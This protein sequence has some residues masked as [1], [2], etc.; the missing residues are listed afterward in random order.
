MGSGSSF[1][2]DTNPTPPAVQTAT[3]ILANVIAAENNAIT[4]IN[5]TLASA[6]STLAA[7]VSAAAQSATNAANSASNA[8]TQAGNS[9]NSAA[10]SA[11]SAS[12]AAAYATGLSIGTVTT[13]T[14]SASIT[15]TAGNLKINFV[16]PTTTYTLP[17]ASASS[18]GGVF[19]STAGANQFATGINTSGQ[20]TYTQPSFTNL[21][22]AAT[23][24]QMAALLST[25]N[26]W[27]A[28]QT[29]GAMVVSGAISGSGFTSLFGAPPAIG[30]T[31][32]NSGSFTTLSAS[33]TVTGSGFA[34]YLASPP[35]IG[36]TSA[37][38]GS[39]TSLS[40]TGTVS[41]VG[42]TNYFASPPSIGSTA[43]SSGAFTTLS[44]T[45][46]TT[47]PTV[48]ATDVSTNAATTQHVTNKIAANPPRGHIAGL[49]LSTAGSSTSFSVAIGACADSTNAMMLKL[50]GLMSKT[51]AAWTAGTGTGALDTGTVAASS[52]YAVFLMTKSDGTSPDIIITKSTAGTAPNPTLPSAYSG[53]LVRYIGSM[54]TNS[55]SQW[56]QFYQFGDS[57]YRAP[58]SDF[59]TSSNYGP[60]LTTLSVPLGVNVNPIMSAGTG[61]SSTGAQNL[62]YIGSGIGSSSTVSVVSVS[63]T[64]G[65]YGQVTAFVTNLSGQL[66][67]QASLPGGNCSIS[68][69]GWSDTR[70]RLL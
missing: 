48:S 3:Q 21:S 44:T 10:A 51:T 35:A 56:V 11:T 32:A 13:G 34:S 49:T 68:T 24:T 55:S 2:Q 16:F 30:G 45:G 14:P 70:G 41:G 25:A 9:A 37:N 20:L 39:F 19:S 7:D 54:Q 69:A 64:Y 6:E 43:P 26:T 12:N 23:A 17:A 1:F 36:G 63:Y 66:F 61:A 33:V 8:T 38:A 52:W 65:A 4:T 18:I 27:A 40:A 57:F 46:T 42:F 15:G 67:I 59:S 60:T 28:T 22:G 47:V 58:V 62:L 5:A 50:T 53:G 29:F 31:T